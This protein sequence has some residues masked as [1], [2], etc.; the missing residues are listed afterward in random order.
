MSHPATHIVY[1]Q[2]EPDLADIPA[3]SVQCSP[4]LPS[5]QALEEMADHSLTGAVI[6]APPGTVERRYVLALALQKL[7]PGAP[8]TAL[9]LNDKGGSR[10]AGELR[11][12]GCEVAEDSR[13]HHRIVQTKCRNNLSDLSAALAEGGLQQHQK[14]GLW[15]QPGV[16]SWD[17][18]D[19]GSALLLQHLPAFHG[20]GADLGCGIGV[21]SRAVLASAKVSALTLIDIDRRAI[22]AAQKNITDPR[23]NFVWADAR[24]QPFPTATLDFVVMNPPFHDT[25]I[26]DKALGQAFIT[27]AAR[28]LKQGGQCWLTANRHL[29]YEALLAEHF[30]RVERIAEA[31]GFKIIKAEK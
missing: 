14:H 29:P 22:S 17:R 7:A 2:P 21:L 4:L 25:G 9:A 23:A 3:G 16:F 20:D 12:M 19:S 28:M 10:I 13:K 8:F 15:T 1:G 26:E 5:A 27:R 11:A 31:D 6:H 24:T 30:S 18:I